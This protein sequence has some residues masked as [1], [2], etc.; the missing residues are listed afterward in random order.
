MKKNTLKN[1]ATSLLSVPGTKY[2]CCLFA[3]A[4]GDC[5]SD[6]PALCEP[7]D[8][9]GRIL[10]ALCSFLDRVHVDHA[11]PVFAHA[12]GDH[13]GETILPVPKVSVLLNG[14]WW[15]AVEEAD[16]DTL[17]ILYHA[18]LLAGMPETVRERLICTLCA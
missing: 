5:L 12:S 16:D 14:D 3:G 1:L 13:A 2:D 9:N 8:T 15:D 7:E 11:E 17:R 10:E 6:G 4:Y 18:D